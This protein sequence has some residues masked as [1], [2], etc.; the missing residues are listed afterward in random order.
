MRLEGCGGPWFE[1]R[2]AL[3]TM[4]PEEFV[5]WYT[6]VAANLLWMIETTRIILSSNNA[7]SGD[8][9]ASLS[10]K[11]KV[12][13][14]KVGR[15]IPNAM[16]FEQN[17]FRKTMWVLYLTGGLAITNILLGAYLESVTHFILHAIARS[18]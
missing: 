4:R 14:A 5:G 16:T 17:L 9:A 7:T 6:S 3:L 15:K 8:V 13:L 12:A 10:E 18:W 2:S 1:T 11:E